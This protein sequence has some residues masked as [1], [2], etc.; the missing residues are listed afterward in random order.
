MTNITPKSRGAVRR[1]DNDIE[2]LMLKNRVLWR[3]AVENGDAASERELTK[4]YQ[5]L[6]SLREKVFEARVKFEMSNLGESQAEKA[7]TDA[8]KDV[9]SFAD[10]VRT[11]TDI[12]NATAQMFSIAARIV[13]LL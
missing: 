10:R 6:W 1:I 12:V 5:D 13:T 8:A 3:K 2:K 4:N 11:L 7:L 9:R